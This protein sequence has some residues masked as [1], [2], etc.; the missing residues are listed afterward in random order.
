MVKIISPSFGSLEDSTI[1]RPDTQTETGRIGL[2]DDVAHSQSAIRTITNPYAKKPPAS[3][4]GTVIHARPAAT[5]P[6][7]AP[8]INPYAKRPPVSKEDAVITTRPAAIVPATGPITNPY[9]KKP[10]A[11]KGDAVINAWPAAIAPATVPITNPY[12]KSGG[13]QPATRRLD[14]TKMLM[15]PKYREFHQHPVPNTEP[16]IPYPNSKSEKAQDP[17]EQY[18]QGANADPKLTMKKYLKDAYFKIDNYNYATSSKHQE[19]LRNNK[20]KIRPP[21]D[22]FAHN[23]VLISDPTKTMLVSP[24]KLISLDENFAA[25]VF[26]EKNIDKD[27]PLVNQNKN[28]RHEILILSSKNDH[29]FALPS[30]TK[31]PK[32]RPHQ[33]FIAVDENHGRHYVDLRA[34]IADKKVPPLSKVSRD[35]LKQIVEPETRAIL[36]KMMAGQSAVGSTAKRSSAV[37]DTDRPNAELPTEA[38]PAKKFRSELNVRSRDR[39]AD[40][41]L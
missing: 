15:D 27:H 30:Q 32:Y 2:R 16:P 33:I 13:A 7:T 22:I 26:K 3:K 5:A 10:P 23:A 37:L 18:Q 4:E 29:V 34:L 21:Q 36:S 17:G 41:T 14:A 39:T 20:S 6:A 9:A 1:A 35:Q 25:K 38:S 28:S 11:S 40:R 19:L 12:A 31:Y 24:R 8:I